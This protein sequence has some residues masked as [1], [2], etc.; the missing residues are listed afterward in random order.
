MAIKVIKAVATPNQTSSEIDLFDGLDVPVKIKKA[1][2]REIGEL[3]VDAVLIQVGNQK[4]PLKG[5]PWPKLSKKYKAFKLSKNLPGKA[6]IEFSG[7]TLDAYKFKVK[8]SGNIE[9]GVFGKKTA[10]IADGHNNISGDS[11]LP[12]RRWIPAEGDEFKPDIAEQAEKIVREAIA[13][14]AK[15]N[16][17]SLKGVTTKAELLS[18]LR[19]TFV[20]SSETQI[21]D[22]ILAEPAL[23]DELVEL[24]LADL[25]DL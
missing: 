12:L 10:P 15:I 18:V 4:S 21:I 7:K 23:L 11:K 19:E 22:A 1:A 25:L 16:K 8:P 9:L 24:G 17:T 13:K 14:G 2:A 6:N 20:G 3:L 5:L